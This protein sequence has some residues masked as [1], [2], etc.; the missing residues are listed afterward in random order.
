M[1]RFTH[2]KLCDSRGGPGCTSSQLSRRRSRYSS[3]PQSRTLPPLLPSPPPPMQHS[4]VRCV[5]T[6][7]AS[8]AA[9][10]ARAKLQPV[11]PATALS[12]AM[13]LTRCLG[14]EVNLNHVCLGCRAHAAKYSRANHR[15][16]AHDHYGLPFLSHL[17]RPPPPLLAQRGVLGREQRQWP[18]Q[19]LQPKTM[20]LHGGI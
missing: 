3:R 14:K 19:K 12:M 4:P 8:R 7:R 2:R 20:V 13:A 5:T 1:E 10:E 11:R 15:R 17:P 16:N 18:L 6:S 9:P